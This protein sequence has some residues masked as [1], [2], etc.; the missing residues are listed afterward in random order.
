[1][2][3]STTYIALE[4]GEGS[5]KTTVI[6]LLKEKMFARQIP[7]LHV[8]EPG[9]TELSEKIRQLVLHGNETLDPKTELFLFMASRADSLERII[10]PGLAA[11]LNIIS[12]R[13]FM[14]S[15]VYQ[16]TSSF[17]SKEIYWLHKKHFRTPDKIFFLDITPKE[18]FA[19]KQ[20][21]A[22]NRFEKKGMDFHQEVY[23]R[24]KSYTASG[25]LIPVDATQ[26]PE[27]VADNIIHQ[28]FGTKQI[29]V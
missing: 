19:R 20:K 25:T 16:A 29:A 4:G 6:E 12:D 26:S 8:T 15:V 10:K 27:A 21:D 7:Y 9:S 22:F 18:A 3:Q 5:G 17:S 28:A 23:Q 24:Y 2:K 11:G 13:S 1:M 14:S